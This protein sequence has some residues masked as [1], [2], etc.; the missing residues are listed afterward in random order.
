MNTGYINLFA[1]LVSVYFIWV[2]LSGLPKWRDK[3]PMLPWKDLNFYA[4]LGVVVLVFDGIDFAM[5]GLEKLQWL[6]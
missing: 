6:N 3:Y 5:R 2:I 1:A 4:W